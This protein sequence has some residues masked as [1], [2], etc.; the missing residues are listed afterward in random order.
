MDGTV[1]GEVELS[2]EGCV[3]G[4]LEVVNEGDSLCNSDGTAEGFIDLAFVGV[5][6]GIE[7]A[8]GLIECDCVGG[9]VG[10]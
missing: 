1:L 3:L 9:E 2:V 5:R 6:V 10:V 7:L 8:L 4:R